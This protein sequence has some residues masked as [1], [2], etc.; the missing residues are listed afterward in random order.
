MGNGQ[1]LVF[2]M[3]VG[4]LLLE[5]G[6]LSKLQRVWGMAFALP[7]TLVPVKDKLAIT[8]NSLVMLSTHPTGTAV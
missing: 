5:F 2:T 7:D 3:L 4:I 6:S 8:P 1:K